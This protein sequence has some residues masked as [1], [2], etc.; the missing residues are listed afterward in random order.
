MLCI[1]M[2][3]TIYQTNISQYRD[4]LLGTLTDMS[5]NPLELKKQFFL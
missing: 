3:S 1:S 5:L 4:I 2:N